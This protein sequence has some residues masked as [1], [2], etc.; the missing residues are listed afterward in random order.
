MPEHKT[1]RYLHA[2]ISMAA[3]GSVYGW[4][5]SASLLLTSEA[6]TP[7]ETLRFFMVLVAGIGA[8]VAL[9][10]A[11]QKSIGSSSTAALGLALWGATLL[12]LPLAG[13][14]RGLS[15]T[16]LV[17]ALL[18]GIGVGVAYLTLLSLFR[19]LMAN[20]TT[21]LSGII[22]PLGFGSGSLIACA[23]LLVRAD[24]Q[25]L[26]RIQQGF[27]LLSL[28]CAVS[29]PFIF[30][31]S[32]PSLSRTHAAP[33]G[34]A[35]G[36]QYLW[37]LLFLNVAP[38]MALVAIT[39]PWFISHGVSQQPAILLM[40]AALPALPLGQLAGAA[41]AKRWGENQAFR[42]MFVLRAMVF[43]IAA[44]GLGPSGSWIVLAITL[45][46]HG[47]G[48]GLIP[49]IVGNTLL[50]EHPASLAYVLSSWGAG[51]IVGIALFYP[52]IGRAHEAFG[53]VG[54]ILLMLIGIALSF[55]Y[56][57]ELIAIR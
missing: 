10:T 13:L 38:G 37:I 22:G 35:R 43:A 17:L 40:C 46:C 28:L 6:W 55:R 56:R 57:K 2:I 12:F 15:W 29:L 49:R 21:L 5:G 30:P 54:L 14:Y 53:F 42:V 20:R 47:G 34:P 16:A 52:G 1:I 24:Q 33:A 45:A 11:P 44:T 8:G 51:G 7:A 39:I 19:D 4:S 36:I 9:A 41:V 32:R 18:G 3:I 23:A 48:F 26:T 25:G 31:G 27:G 50:R